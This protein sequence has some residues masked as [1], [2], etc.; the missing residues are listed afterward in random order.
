MVCIL[1]LIGQFIS[2]DEVFTESVDGI[3]TVAKPESTP[4]TTKV[5]EPLVRLGK[6]GDDCRVIDPVKLL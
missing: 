1:P 6:V 3:F 5:Y 4:P 2:V